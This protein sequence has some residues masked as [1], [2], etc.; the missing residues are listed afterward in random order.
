[1]YKGKKCA[2][3]L[4]ELRLLAGE[5][6]KAVFLSRF[7]EPRMCRNNPRGTTVHGGGSLD[8]ALPTLVTRLAGHEYL[9]QMPA[10]APA[11][12]LGGITEQW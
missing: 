1:M 11:W 8:N 3:A 4:P 5:V 6:S 2:K 7:T 12:K 9:S 10:Q